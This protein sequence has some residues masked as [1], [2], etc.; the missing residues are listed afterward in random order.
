MNVAESIELSTAERMGAAANEFFAVIARGEQPSVDEFAQRYPDIGDHIRRAFPALLLVGGCSAEGEIEDRAVLGNDE[1]TLGEFRLIRE[2]GRGGMGI[3]YEAEQLSLGRRVALKVLPFAALLDEKALHRFR[4]EVRAAAT[5]NHPN[6]VAVHSVG[7]QRGVHFYAMELVK[8]RSLAEIIAQLRMHHEARRPSMERQSATLNEAPSTLPSDETEPIAALT[9]MPAFQSHDYFRAVAR[10]GIQAAEA[11]QHAHDQGVLHRDIKPSNLMLDR[12]SKLYITDFGLAR[13]EADAGLTATGDILGTLRY[14]PPEQALA[15]RVVIDHRADIYSLGTTLYEVIALEPAFGEIERA[16]LL[17]QIAFEEPSPLRSLDRRVPAELETIVH[18]AMAKC[19]D[20]RY[21]TAQ[22]LADDLRAFCDDRPIK[23]RPVS[24]AD[25][26]RKWSRRHQSLVTMACGALAVLCVI[27]SVSTIVVKRA[28]SRAVA[29]LDQTSNLLYTTDMAL[30]FQS[31]EKGWHDNVQTILER[32]RPADGDKDRRGFEWYLLQR[33]AQKPN[34]A[35]LAGHVG[36]VNEFA[37]FPDN[38]RLASVGN[39]G[40]LRI[41]NTHSRQLERTIR[42]CDE[43]LS[44]VAVSPDGRYVAAGS[45]IIFLCDLPNDTVVKLF[46]CE[47]TAESLVFSP[48]GN[49][50]VAGA[51]YDNVSEISL[52]GK[53]IKRVSCAARVESLDYVAHTDLLLVPSRRPLPDE[54]DKGIAE[55]W[56]NSL[57]ELVQVF[58]DSTDGHKSRIT[59]ARS[60]PCGQYIL[61]GER[62]YR[63]VSLFERTTGS[64]IGTTLPSRDEVTDV[65]YSPLGDRIAVAYRDGGIECFALRHDSNG[66]PSFDGRAFMVGAHEG[67]TT[68]TRF[69]DGGLLASSGTDGLIRLIEIASNSAAGFDV[70][71]FELTDLSLSPEGTHLCINADSELIMMDVDRSEVVFRMSEPGAIY[72]Q[73]KWS[74]SGEIVAVGSRTAET[75]MIFDCQGHVKGTV[76]DLD[77]INNLAISPDGSL[78]AII[79]SDQLLLVRVNSGGRIYRRQLDS[80]GFDVAFSHDGTRL[81]Y[82]QESGVCTVIDVATMS[83]VYEFRSGS[84]IERLEFSPDDSIIASGHGDSVI[85]LWNAEAGAPCG[86]LSGHENKISTLAFSPDG[87]ALLSSARDGTVRLWSV[88]ESRNYGIV[89]RQDRFDSL[90]G[91]CFVSL[92]SNGRRLAVGNKTPSSDRFDAMIWNLN[93]E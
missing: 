40:T 41:W 73:P 22:Q 5:L 58:D 89:Y 27:L 61:A 81:A 83:D 86:E 7:E 35:V 51:R 4:N 8:G 3:V 25:R 53:L 31:F 46:D 68:C 66:R 50:L 42:I 33:L 47:Y 18:K 52:R 9:T 38:R 92:S 56:E 87:N 82:G 93:K 63:R 85:R 12:T 78:L 59:L 54:N 70:T 37:V 1:K 21:Q 19:R 32:Y 49:K 29:A 90:K 11:I 77:L 91:N 23:A 17:K 65:A 88:D 6:I 69:V 24:W 45:R 60:S 43:P 75:A 20:E 2:I 64:L 48:D 71:S 13:I 79:E 15:Q 26:A 10:L 57:A 76:R 28:Q 30:A 84:S 34:S 44:S 74:R 39:D 14:M 16:E 55:L 36:S 67:E 80:R 72:T 62:R